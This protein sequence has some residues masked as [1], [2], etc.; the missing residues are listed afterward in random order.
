MSI[1][2]NLTIALTLVRLLS[3]S[4]VRIP[5]S[6]HNFRNLILSVKLQPLNLGSTS[7]S[8][9]HKRIRIK[10]SPLKSPV[11]RKYSN[12]FNRPGMYPSIS[13]CNTKS[14]NC[15]KQLCT[16]STVTSSVNGR[17]FS[18]INNSELD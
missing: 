11:L 3:M 4:F 16:K 1:T 12:L 6:D 13:K 10:L 15:C 5:H 14:C 2:N 7:P 17:I 18:V 9:F 8:I